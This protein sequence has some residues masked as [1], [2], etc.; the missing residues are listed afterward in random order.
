MQLGTKGRYAVSALLSMA[1][2]PFAVTSLTTISEKE[3]ITIPYLEQL[4][5]KLRR[6][7]IVKSHRG[8]TGGYSF[9]K[10]IKDISVAQIVL[11]VDENLYFT[12]CSRGSTTSCNGSKNVC[13]THHLWEE[14][15]NRTFRFLESVTLEDVL[16]DKV[17]T[18][19]SAKNLVR[20]Q[21]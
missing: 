16:N 2:D 12:R 13:K 9:F 5:S 14:L 17:E 8:Q 21:A 20:K 19:D 3:N 4:F 11:A 15:T 10:D 7:G 18:I 1:H 6:A